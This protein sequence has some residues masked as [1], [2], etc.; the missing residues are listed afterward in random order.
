MKKDRN[1]KKNEFEGNWVALV[2]PFK[3]G[4]ID[5]KSFKKLI[6]FVIEKGCDGIVPCGTTGEAATL[7]YDEHIRVIELAVEFAD[8]R[9]KVMAGTGSNS[10]KEA[11]ELTKSAEKIGADAVLL[12][13]P[14]Y[15]RPTQKGLYE[16]FKKI[17]E[18][19]QI[20]QFLYNIPGRTAVNIE[21]E[22][23][24]KL[25]YECK[26]IKGIKEASGNIKQI[27][28]IIKGAPEGFAVLSGDD[29]MTLPIMAIGG[30]GVISSV[31]NIVPKEMTELVRNCLEGNFQ[32]ARE[33]HLYLLELFNNL[34]IETN[35]IP[36]KTA[37]YLMGIIESP[38]LRLP[39]SPLSEKNLPILK[40]TLRKY[41]LIPE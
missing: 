10:T 23:T 41:K 12:I 30:K 40:D 8:R 3:D 16:H 15:N 38:E 18:E 31:S 6:N 28:E 24:L 4:K 17:A 35:P 32:K 1:N 20:P 2:T 7:D 25:A 34:F 39:L 26:N 21:A 5:E 22:T 36:V 37:L 11:I 27:S 14:Y 13:A 19:C 9:V 33:I 29:I